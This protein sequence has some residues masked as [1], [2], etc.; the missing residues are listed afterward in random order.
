MHK[1]KI[2]WASH[3]WNPF[4]GCSKVSQGCKHCYALTMSRRLSSNPKTPWYKG[5]VDGNGNWSGKLFRSPDNIFNSPINM[6]K[7]ALIFVNSMSD[8]FYTSLS[9]R[10]IAEVFN[11]MIRCPQHLFLVL[12]KRA[13]RMRSFLD[14]MESNINYPPNNI[15]LGISA[16]DQETYNY[17]CEDLAYTKANKK[18]LSLE[19]LLGPIK[20]FSCSY[21]SDENK[22]I[23]QVIVGGESGHGARPMKL[24]WARSLRDECLE[25]KIPFFMKQ[26]VVNGKKIPF[27]D[28]PKDLQV[29]QTLT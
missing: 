26:I 27:D 16:E 11:I 7:K 25:H 9:N 12:T 2:D 8:L 13:R 28:F 1:T 6:K 29:R 17:R 15:C 19:P 22:K 20:L 10:N 24:D 4:V 23:S 3:V 5:T 18:F 14:I 21:S